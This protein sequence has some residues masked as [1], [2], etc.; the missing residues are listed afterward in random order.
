MAQHVGAL[1]RFKASCEHVP[2]PLAAMPG[3][4]GKAGPIEFLRQ[5]SLLHAR[6][7]DS[8]NSALNPQQPK[9]G[10]WWAT[11][12]DGVQEVVVENVAQFVAAIE[13]LD[14]QLHGKWGR[15]VSFAAHGNA[16][17]CLS[18]MIRSGY[19]FR[20]MPNCKYELLTSL[21]RSS[22]SSGYDHS[23]RVEFPICRSFQRYASTGSQHLPEACSANIWALLAFM[24]VRR[25]QF[26][27]LAH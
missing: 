25:I 16:P 18:R 21:L 23:R 26:V 6:A 11:A 17:S 19:V 9:S 12:Q 5:Q 3:R 22:K 20:G 14:M 4:R 27:A 7:L 8:E 24:Q 10:Q 13:S 1:Q 15:C 2:L